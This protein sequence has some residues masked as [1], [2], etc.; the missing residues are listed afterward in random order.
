MK[1]FTFALLILL[2]SLSFSF[3]ACGNSYERMIEE[4]DG[5]YFSAEPPKLPAYS[6]N[7]SDF[8]DKEMLETTYVFPT[9]TYIN[10]EAPEGGVSYSWKCINMD[11]TENELSNKRILYFKTPGPFKE[12]EKNRLLLTVT[13]ID[14]NNNEITYLDEAMVFLNKI[15]SVVGREKK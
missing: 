2:I 9:D 14:T 13:A 8:S 12:K 10:L 15:D 1:R 3:T 7:N 5:K 6:I 4:F 11:G